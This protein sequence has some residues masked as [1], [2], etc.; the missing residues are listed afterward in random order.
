MVSG[1]GAEEHGAGCAAARGT[2]VARGAIGRQHRSMGR[3]CGGVEVV[4]REHGEWWSNDV[5]AA[6]RQNRV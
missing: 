4:A 6:W 5:G 3:R 1:N 2:A